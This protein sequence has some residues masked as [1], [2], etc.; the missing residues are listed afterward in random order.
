MSNGLEIIRLNDGLGTVIQY[1][2]ACAPFVREA[3]GVPAAEILFPLSEKD[4]QCLKST[5]S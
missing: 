4:R 3:G 1:S 5:N 2:K